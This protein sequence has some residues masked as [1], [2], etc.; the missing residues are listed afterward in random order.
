MKPK[1]KN[2]EALSQTSN[3]EGIEINSFILIPVILSSI[4]KKINF[5]ILSEGGSQR[6]SERGRRR[7]RK[8]KKKPMRGAERLSIW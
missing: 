2:S 6:D 1:K 4:I 7:G 3:D 8:K 5:I